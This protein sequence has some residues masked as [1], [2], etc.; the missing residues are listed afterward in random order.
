MAILGLLF[1]PTDQATV[2]TINETL[3]KTPTG[4]L[5][6]LA[7]LMVP[8]KVGNQ[9]LLSFL[10]LKQCRGF[11]IIYLYQEEGLTF[12]TQKSNK[13]THYY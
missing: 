13:P 5:L 6:T 1:F 2:T 10:L 7:E 3:Y 11:P 12:A 4:S 9:Y 8:T